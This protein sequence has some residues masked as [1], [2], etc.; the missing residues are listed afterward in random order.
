M[1][2]IAS[3]TQSGRS[4][5]IDLALYEP[6]PMMSIGYEDIKVNVKD[7]SFIR[8]K[9]KAFISYEIDEGELAIYGEP[10]STPE[11]GC[12]PYRVG[13]T[14]K[15]TLEDFIFIGSYHLNT[16][17]SEFPYVKITGDKVRGY[18]IKVFNLDVKKA[19]IRGVP[20]RV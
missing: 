1:F 18:A 20:W 8:I 4:F 13:S 5:C 17:L 2:G 16:K 15:I 3:P 12:I 7:Y 11:E 10:C 19:V 6:V 9:K 14:S